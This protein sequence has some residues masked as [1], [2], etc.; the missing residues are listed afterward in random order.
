MKNKTIPKPAITH[1]QYLDMSLFWDQMYDTVEIGESE[2]KLKG[3]QYL[4][5]TDG[6]IK[7][8]RTG[9]TRYDAYKKRAVYIN[10]GKRTIKKALGLMH[11]K[12]YASKLPSKIE[13]LRSDF[14][15]S[16]ESIEDFARELN[17]HQ[18]IYSRMGLLID[19]N[20]NK[21]EN[22][23]IVTYTAKSIIDWNE[24]DDRSCD[25]VLLNESGYEF[26]YISKT[27]SPVAKY[28]LLGLAYS[29]NGEKLAQPT[30]YTVVLNNETWASFDIINPVDME[31][32]EI[33]FP[34]IKGKYL[35]Y[36]PFVFCNATTLYPEPQMPVLIDQS[37]LSLAY[38]RGDADYRQA[39][40]FQAFA[41]LILAGFDEEQIKDNIRVDGYLCSSD[42][43]AKGSYTQTN[44]TGL[45][46]MRLSLSELK[47]ESEREGIV[48]TDK[49]GVES[50]K[51]LSTRITLQTSDLTEIAKTSAS[52]ILWCCWIIG[53]WLGLSETELNSI[54]IIPNLDFNL[55]NELPRSVF[56]MWQVYSNGGIPEEDFY[57]WLRENNYTGYRTF[58]D[59]KS[60]DRQ[61]IIEDISKNFPQAV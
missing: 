43:N 2:V 32:V 36:I 21:P 23:Y 41:I 48:I 55:E 35:N 5:K 37:N 56:E 24:L 18:L 46:E 54:D 44:G 51:A 29:Y 1:P 31:G 42:A 53:E 7:D 28:R 9:A 30:Y 10:F 45:T 12:E 34:S 13:Y 57:K 25:F 49:D 47:K 60:A 59:W 22:P 4:P 8:S 20:E 3:T 50:G 27:W 19:F 39:L 61:T 52:A 38:Y 11:H 15:I 6:M 40:Y 17:R 14:T 58:E 33:I 26:D 16:G